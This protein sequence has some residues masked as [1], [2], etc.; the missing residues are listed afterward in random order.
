MLA[1]LRFLWFPAAILLVVVTALRLDREYGWHGPH[2]PWLGRLLVLV[3]ALLIAWCW[4]LFVGIGEG[5]PHP[6]AA[7]TKHL[8]I[9][10]PYRY[11]RNPMMYGVGTL[12][13]GS[14]LWIGSIGLWLAFAFF[15]LFISLFVPFYEERDMERRF[16]EEYR[17]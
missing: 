2:L 9:A 10:G 8:V 16:G 11:V 14:A 4:V 17:E 5:T 13:V 3:A 15:V 12:L 7:K 1:V 6:F